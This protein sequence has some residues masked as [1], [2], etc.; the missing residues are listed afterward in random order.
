MSETV[1]GACGRT[2]SPSSGEAMPAA[3][4]FASV[5]EAVAAIAAGRMVV[6]VDS[7]RRENEYWPLTG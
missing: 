2:E 6:V 7:P 4:G 1:D 3:A 5:E